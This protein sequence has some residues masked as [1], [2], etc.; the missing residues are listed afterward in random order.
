MANQGERKRACVMIAT[1]DFGFGIQLAD[2]LAAHGYQAVLVRS[3]EHAIDEC[4]ELKPQAVFIGLGQS[5]ATTPIMLHRLHRTIEQVCPGI[6]VITMGDRASGKLIE[7][8]S[9]G[10]VRHVLVKPI[11]FISIGR[12]LQAELKRAFVSPASSSTRSDHPDGCAS[13]TPSHRRAVHGE[14]AT[15]IG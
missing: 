3:V 13:E 6:T 10:A 11:D 9:G 2:W 7:V 4:R 12:L 15:W 5:D 14:A 8:I 1:Q